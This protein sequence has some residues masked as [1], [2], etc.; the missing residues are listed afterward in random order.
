MTTNRSTRLATKHPIVDHQTASFTS[1]FWSALQHFFSS[2]VFSSRSAGNNKRCS[3]NVVVLLPYLLF[4]PSVFFFDFT[5][6]SGFY[7]DIMDRKVQV[8]Y[9]LLMKGK[10]LRKFI[11]IFVFFL[12]PLYLFIYFLLLFLLFC[13]FKKQIEKTLDTIF[14]CRITTI[15]RAEMKGRKIEAL[16]CKRHVVRV[17]DWL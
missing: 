4:V 6:S 16:K 1:F 14:S 8:L 9:A 5:F 13:Y 11:F 12:F 15:N 7:Q 17:A 2:D 3:N 10:L